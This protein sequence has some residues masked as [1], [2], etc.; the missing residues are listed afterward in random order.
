M[1]AAT[2]KFV[3][4]Q[5][6]LLGAL[7]LGLSVIL[8][9]ALGGLGTAWLSLSG[10]VPPEVAQAS[11]SEEITR[12]F[13]LQ[14]QEWKNVLIRGRD[15]ALL[16]KHLSAFREQGRKVQ[17]STEALAEAT[18]DPQARTLA[19]DF[20]KAHLGLQR[21]YEAAL[22]KFAE[23]GYDTQVGDQ[24]VKGQ[25]RAPSHTLEELVK[26]SKTLA[27][28]AVL[29]SSQSAQHKLV[30]SAVATIAAALCLVAVLGWWI[31]RSIVRPIEN[32]A[33]AARQVAAGDLSARAA[34]STR[35]E[36]G[37]LGQAM[38]QVVNTLTDV[39]TA[40]ADMA[41]RH[42]AGQ[43]SY[44][45]DAQA[46]PGA[47]GRMV[48]DTNGLI[49]AKVG[50]I[51]DML[52][53]MQH[54]A[55]GDMSVDMPRLPG[56]K[57]Q[58]T[59]AMDTTKRN[60]AAINGEIRGLVDAAAAGDFATRGN[61]EAYQFEFRAMVSGVNGLMQNVDQNL[62][63]LSQLLKAIA[64]GDLTARMHGN[65]QG[66]FARMRDDANATVQR[67]TD[68][69]G[70]ITVAAQTIRTASAEI[71]AGNNDLAQRTE[72]QAANLEETA[73]SM[74]ELTSTVRQNADTAQQ[75][76][77][78]AQAAAEIAGRGGEMVASVVDTMGEIE[79]SSKKIAE[80]IS[81]I[82]GI[83]FQ[84]N[85]LALNAA[86]EAARAGE[87]GRG[88][89]V[90]ASEVRA[91]AQ[92][93]AGAAKEVKQLIDASVD[94]VERGSARVDQAGQTMQ[95]IVQSV[96]QVTTL[97]AE[98]SAASR[99]QSSGI[100][101]VARTVNDMDETTQRNAALVEEASAAARAME[102]QAVELS[103]AVSVFR[104]DARRP[105]LAAAA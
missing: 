79:V 27:D 80:I 17:A 38:G 44:R 1:S 45:M 8:L 61:A 82:D 75:A 70:D 59:E 41:Q 16:D 104:L 74:E 10:K 37:L 73:A 49:G 84:T 78:G 32:V 81:V 43:M 34:V 12:D 63:E 4:L 91:L 67:L 46:F 86:V 62:A 13:R 39:S 11:S 15:P 26:R 18:Q 94:S 83:A 93:S 89:A 53:V 35:D 69:V 95:Q 50:L 31:R 48:D 72:Q 105:R 96:Q 19:Q 14:V 28:A 66:V 88:F 24:L 98:I 100:E 77:R 3:S 30:L 57:A 64:D 21:N 51:G 99:E 90:V 47:Y 5:S 68:I 40:Q 20:A 56:E 92:R 87:Q 7:A 55:V 76:S 36:I 23:A 52:Q 2:P 101:Q 33:R 102:E 58:I 6:K 85:I 42:E 97:I 60:L 9:C 103:E 22:G 54:Y 29:A 65:Q 71:A 25:D